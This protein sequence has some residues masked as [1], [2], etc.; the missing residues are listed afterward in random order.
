MRTTVFRT[1]A[2][3][4]LSTS[5]AGCALTARRTSVADLKYNPAR[6]EDKTVS[7]EGV[8]TTSWGVPLMPY[9]L[10]KVDDG[11][12]EVTVI[13]QSGRAPGKGARVRVKGKVNELATFGGQSIGLH[14]QERD[15]DFK[16]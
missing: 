1:L 16:F 13:S 14:L 15:L 10:Y 8:V 6:Y 3:I 7:V 4:V 2:A 11:T 5:L 9:K 12:G